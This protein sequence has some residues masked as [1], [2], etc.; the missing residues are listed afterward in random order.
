MEKEQFLY[1]MARLSTAFHE[2]ITPERF[3]LYYEFLG[4]KDY[5]KLSE[6]INEIISIKKWFPKIGEIEELLNPP[7]NQ[8]LEYQR[9]LERETKENQE[10]FKTLEWKEQQNEVKQILKN[11]YQKIE[12]KI[13]PL[14]ALQGEEA[15][16][17]EEKREIAKLQAQLLK[18][19]K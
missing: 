14:P 6:V 18:E 10:M 4:L 15:K 11:I 7:L 1:L 5:E 17:F 13:N 9:Y 12:E 3:N 8:E 16:R 2:D 19:T